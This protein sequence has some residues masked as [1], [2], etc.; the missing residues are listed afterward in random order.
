[1]KKQLHT[2]LLITFF[3]MGSHLVNGQ[4]RCSEVKQ[5]WAATGTN[6]DHN[7]RSDTFDI[8]AY[9]LWL[10]FT[11]LPYQNMEG[12]ATVVFTPQFSGTSQ[13]PLDLQQLV[14]DSVYHQGSWVTFTQ[15][16]DLVKINLNTATTANSID[17]VTVYYSG[18]PPED[19]TGWGGVHFDT[20][21]FYNLGVGFGEN[22]HVYGRAWFPCFDNFVEKSTY[23]LHITTAG[24]RSA[25]ANGVRT[26]ITTQ[27]SNTTYHWKM[28]DPIPSYLASFAISNYQEITYTHSGINGSLPVSIAALAQDTNNV[29]ASFIHL[30]GMI[31]S[32]ENAFG[33]YVWQKVGYAMTITG[34]MEHTTSIHLPISLADGTLAGEEIIAHE[35]AHHWW[36]DLITCETAEDMWI[37]E[38]MAEF[39]SHFYHEAVY[40]RNRYEETVQNNADLV[41]RRAHLIDGAY[42]AIAGVPHSLTYGTHVY[43]KGAMVGHNLRGYMGDSAFY[44]ACAIVMNQSAFGNYNTT[45]FRMALENA[46]GQNLVPFFDAWVTAEGYPQFSIDSM[47]VTPG[48]VHYQVDL[49]LHQRL[50][51]A[52]A[53]YTQVPLEV[54]LVDAHGNSEIHEI[55]YGTQDAVATIIS[56]LD[57]KFAVLHPRVSILTATTQHLG[58]YMSGNHNLPRSR[59]Q[60]NYSGTDSVWA[61]IAHHLVGPDGKNALGYKLSDQR[62]WT[63]MHDASPT[64]ITLEWSYNGDANQGGIDTV[65][66]ENTEDSLRLL[67]R[68]DASFHWNEYPHY[69]KNSGFPTDKKGNMELT[70]VL[71]GDYVL[72]NGSEGLSIDPNSSVKTEIHLFPNPSDG[73]FELQYDAK[74]NARIIEAIYSSS[75]TLIH[76]KVL[77]V[78]P[79]EN[80]FYIDLTGQPS[81]MYTLH[82]DGKVYQLMVIA[83]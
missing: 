2:Y 67:Y 18:Q 25:F 55:Q 57:P 70:Q 42:L 66:L 73:R 23:T 5:Q 63:V 38:G 50:H 3:V 65:L 51:Q 41:L 33:P 54:L 61:Y 10:D 72:A 58:Y 78:G 14:V 7:P 74:D 36:G 62:Y 59:G 83:K 8:E 19:P 39:A 76:Q 1:M 56:A 34:A 37:N 21:Y 6:I 53:L 24:G 22:P 13:L 27:G 75:G 52:P 35:L 49:A 48:A 60:M 45:N 68:P 47:E 29:K 44:A 71:P 40:G 16:N 12:I 30:P 9:N 43:Q 80:T 15:A 20:P 11:A 17:S 82:W 79:G 69:I 26:A 64:E 32:Y 46:S 31:D 28:T 77:E 4:Y 81:G